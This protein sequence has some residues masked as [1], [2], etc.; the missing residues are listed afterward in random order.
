LNTLAA[1]RAGEVSDYQAYNAS[2][3]FRLN[4]FCLYVISLLDI[5]FRVKRKNQ[6][7]LE[8]IFSHPI[9]GNIRWSDIET[10]LVSL[11]AEILEREGSRV[12]I[13]FPGKLP[14]VY[15]RPHP[16]PNTDK[17]AIASLRK[18]LNSVGIKP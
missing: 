13:I 4:D 12:A 14:A 10:M 17:G 9:S 6:K 5:F 1:I 15:H 3:R 8:A 11:G 7:T 18:W 2:G 16:S